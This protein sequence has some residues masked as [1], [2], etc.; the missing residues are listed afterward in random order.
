M[1][2][3]GLGTFGLWSGQLGLLDAG[4]ARTTVRHLEQIGFTTVWIN[5]SFAKEALSHA[6]FLLDWTTNITVATG[7]AS[8][9]A[10]DP[11]T[12]SNGARTLLD[13]HP[14]RFVLGV[15]A[16]HGPI[17]AKR[18]HAYT[19]PLE[20]TRAYLE[21]M[22]TAPHQ[23]AIRATAAPPV[24][25]GALGPR[26]LELARDLSDGAHPYLVPVEHTRRARAILGPHR[27]LAPE[28]AIVFDPDAVRARRHGREHLAYY[29]E[30]PNYVRNLRRLGWNDEDLRD[31]GSDALIDALI[32]WGEPERIATL[33]AEHLE[34]G[35]DHVALQV[36]TDT[37]DELF[38][39]QLE[40][41]AARLLT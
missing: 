14:G 10:R 12:A 37:P 39:P 19:R 13:A 36:L 16:S 29:L 20:Q 32:A 21:A 23:G 40:H 15:G 18:G 3:L 9:W 5:E 28:Q 8:I 25:V 6:A 38:D 2:G 34:A 31:G 33:V 26:M 35:A 17:V 1:T 22:N 27:T 30:L 41:L 7:I 4:T 24:L 11:V